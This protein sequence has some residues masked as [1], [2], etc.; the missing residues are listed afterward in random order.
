MFFSV[1][2]L[3]LVTGVAVA[4]SAAPTLPQTPSAADRAR[5]RYGIHLD[6]GER[7]TFDGNG[8]LIPAQQ[9]YD[10]LRDLLTGQPR[11]KQYTRTQDTGKDYE[12]GSPITH[13]ICALYDMNDQLVY[14]WSEYGYRD[15]FGDF[16]VKLDSWLLNSMVGADKD[17]YCALWNV[18]TG[19]EFMNHVE[20][21]ERIDD[22]AILLLPPDYNSSPL[23]VLETGGDKAVFKPFPPGYGH[24]GV[25]D[26]QGQLVADIPA[27]DEKS[28]EKVIMTKG[29]KVL[30]KGN[31]LSVSYVALRGPFISFQ[32]GDSQSIMSADGKLLYTI[33]PQ[34]ENYNY[35]DGELVVLSML[36]DASGERIWTRQLVKVDGTQLTEAYDSLNPIY[37][38][39]RGND[40]PAEMFW[41]VR[42]E[43]IDILDRN[44]KVVTTRT[45]P[46]LRE[47]YCLPGLGYTYEVLPAGEQVD[48]D[49]LCGLLNEKL[50]TVIEPDKYSMISELYGTLAEGGQGILPLFWGHKTTPGGLK[51]YDLLDSSG[52]V[53]AENL[54]Q[55]GEAGVDRVAVVKGF[56]VG[57]MD[58]SGNWIGRHSLFG[59]FEDEKED[60]WG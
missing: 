55:I 34:C 39:E 17:S 20:R 14:D 10:I 36:K 7:Y 40:D 43:T 19:K 58:Y 44:G 31:E 32:D 29:Y 57:V 6:N 49:S 3:S 27:A 5:E 45:I 47:V 25:W 13:T 12:D 51:R 38:N 18:K 50:E 23:G 30:L 46:H 42:R 59:T 37:R 24:A 22:S 33:P 4:L 2:L 28:T 8:S 15:A 1:R 48:L 41:G 35:F 60:L 52:K 54:T 16:V 26:E 21:V 11:Y 53:I 9:Q 56:S